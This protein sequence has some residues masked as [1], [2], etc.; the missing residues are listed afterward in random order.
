[1]K[2]KINTLLLVLII[3]IFTTIIVKFIFHFSW[4]ATILFNVLLLVALSL[5][6]LKN[7]LSYFLIVIIA[8]INFLMIVFALIPENKQNIDL[9]SFYKN[10]KNYIQILK[11]DDDEVLKQNKAMIIINPWTKVIKLWEIEHK[12]KF[13]IR[14]NDIITYYSK[15]K[16]L[17]TIVN[18]ILW[19]WTIIQL[20]PQTK[21]KMEKIFKNLQN[22]ALSETKVKVE[23][24]WAWIRIIK[25]ILTDKGFNVNTDD[26]TLVIRWTSTFIYKTEQKSIAYSYDHIVEVKNKEWKTKIL[27]PGQAVQFT[28]DKIENIDLTYIKQLVPYFEYQL[29]NFIQNSEKLIQSYK[30]QLIN[31]INNQ[32]SSFNKT[33]LLQKI[34]NLKTKII[35]ENNDIKQIIIWKKEILISTDNLKDIIFIPLNQDLQKEKLDYIYQISKDNLDYAKSYIIQ[36]INQALDSWKNINFDNILELLKI[37]NIQNLDKI[38]KLLDF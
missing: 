11:G 36:K 16:N 7:K 4:N 35:S 24:W 18:L 29:Q 10:Q 21:I 25:T 13:E 37:E 26:W 32:V 30:N 12:A 8:S 20:Q 27:K 6:Q 23:K 34:A 38:L 31:F 19:D 17:R 15:N 5:T 14:E 22:L 28:K 3:L 1:M 2:K 9:K 33:N